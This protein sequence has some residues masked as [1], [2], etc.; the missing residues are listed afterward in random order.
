MIQI[1]HS[2]DI[3]IGHLQFND[4]ARSAFAETLAARKCVTAFAVS[5]RARRHLA[6][7]WRSSNELDEKPMMSIAGSAELETRI[8]SSVDVASFANREATTSNVSSRRNYLSQQ[9]VQSLDVPA[10]HR[11]DA[12]TDQVFEARYGSFGN[13]A[14]DAIDVPIE[15][16]EG[17]L[18]HNGAGSHHFFTAIV[19][20][21]SGEGV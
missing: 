2:Q 9:D 16:V 5:A 11:R 18:R 7:V 15:R 1:H 17:R 19:L 14:V 8:A 20:D 3:Q 13:A 10:S 21:R 12:G 6:T 4:R